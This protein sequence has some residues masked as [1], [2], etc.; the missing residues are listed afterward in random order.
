MQRDGQK[1]STISITQIFC[2]FPYRNTKASSWRTHVVDLK[3]INNWLYI[4]STF[5][6]STFTPWNIKISKK[7]NKWWEMMRL[8]SAHNQNEFK[9]K[10]RSSRKQKNGRNFQKLKIS[11]RK[12]ECWSNLEME[13]QKWHLK[14][15]HGS[16]SKADDEKQS[17]R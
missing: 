7:I 2:L 12:S 16:I 5:C 15:N 1:V 14:M 11:F 10:W 4:F 9:C 13:P 17:E 3:K 6:F 8:F